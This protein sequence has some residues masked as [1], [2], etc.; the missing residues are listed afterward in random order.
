MNRLIP[1]LLTVALTGCIKEDPAIVAPKVDRIYTVSDFL[2]QPELRK[3]FFTMCGNDPGQSAR[4]PNCINVLNAERIASAGTS[5]P[6]I[7]P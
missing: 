4:D 6:R 1:L 3:K 7:V 5:I 2:A